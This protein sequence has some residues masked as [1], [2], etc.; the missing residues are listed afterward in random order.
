MLHRVYDPEEMGHIINHP[1]V[2]PGSSLG[3]TDHFDPSPLFENPLNV[4][5]MDD[6]GGFMCLYEGGGVYDCHSFFVPEGRGRA[7]IKVARESIRYMFDVVKA[8][9]LVGRSPVENMA[10]RKFSR[11]AGFSVVGVEDHRFS[12][13]G[14]VMECEKTSYL[15]SDFQ[16]RS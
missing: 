14:P 11:L 10:V 1:E 8:R 15:R 7:A 6:I 12:A 13:D 3:L 9:E 2:L 5:L 16:C 4:C